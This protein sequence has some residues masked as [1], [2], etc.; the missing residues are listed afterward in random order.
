MGDRANHMKQAL[1]LL[2]AEQV[3]IQKTSSVYETSPVGIV[4]QANFLNMVVAVTTEHSPLKLL[5]LCLMIEAELG[6]VRTR[7]W[8][9][10]TIDIDILLYNDEV[11]NQER[12]IVPH[13]YLPER[14]FVLVP[15]AEIAGDVLVGQH[16]SVNQLLARLT[17]NS[18]V[19]KVKPAVKIMFITAPVGSGHVRAAQAVEKALNEI[20]VLQQCNV[21]TVQYSLFDFIPKKVAN[22]ILSIYFWVLTCCPVIYGGMYQWG[23]QSSLALVGRKLFNRF[24][25]RRMSQTIGEQQPDIIVCTHASAGGVVAELIK[26]KVCAVP[27]VAV[28]T[29][30][31]V[32]R[33]WVYPEVTRYFVAL[34]GLKQYLIRYAIPSK[35]VMVTGIPVDPTFGELKNRELLQQKYKLDSA[36]PTLLFMGGGQGLLPLVQLVQIITSFPEPMQLIVVAGQNVNAV[37]QLQKLTL[38]AH[39]HLFLFGF[40]EMIDELMAIADV[41][42]TKPGGMTVAEALVAQLPLIIYHPLPGQEQANT[43]YLIDAGVARKADNPVELAQCL[44]GLLKQQSV[45]CQ[46]KKALSRHTQ[47]DAARQIAQEILLIANNFSK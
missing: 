27:L 8:G 33:L 42:I 19:H 35:R 16:G 15:L 13:P 44:R 22:L 2:K 18:A 7:K 34:E 12:L 37:K 10:R 21:E 23:N 46:M 41:I 43:Q 3:C 6:R 30:F 24:M 1:T 31:V 32:H 39:H 38:P 4:E 17:D 11:I 5:D 9:P 28:V 45:A 40:V 14:R 20:A 25:A 36:V 29:D 47:S 26:H